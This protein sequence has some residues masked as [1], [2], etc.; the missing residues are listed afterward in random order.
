MTQVGPGT[1]MGDLLRRYWHPVA[2]ESEFESRSTKP[3]RLMGEDLLLFKTLKGEFG[4]VARRC[5]HRGSDLGFGI[6]EEDGLRCSYHGWQYD[7]G[8]ACVHRPFDETVAGAAA[9]RRAVKIAAY[10]VKIKGGMLWAYLGPL[11]APELPDWETF[12]WPNCFAQVVIAEIP[13]NWLQCQENTVDPV[14]FEWMHNNGPKRRAGD[15]GPFSPKTLKMGIE[16]TEYGLLSRRYR[17]GTDESTP[18]WS[19]GRAILWPNGW[20]FGHHFEWKV[21]IDD[22]NTL[23]ITWSVLHVPRECE[24]YAQASIPTWHAPIKDQNG[25]W[26]ISHVGNQD[27]VAWI[28]QGPIADRTHEILGASD[29]GVVTLRRRLLE[30]LDKVAKGQDPRGLIRDPARNVKI[31][32]PCIAREELMNGLPREQMEKHPV[33]GPF[34]RD[35][36]SMAGQPDAVRQAFEEAMGVRQSSFEVHSFVPQ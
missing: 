33:M 30:D 32:L 27:I 28:S 18:L 1:R 5:A 3:I 2:G 14:H 9:L 21:P 35:F 25:E 29:V 8:G 31:P 23:F 6:V 16:D 34:L 17:E 36:Y 4:L 20:Y 7:L 10:P 12:S 11:P 13:C 19:V 15:F 24:P 22:F 26:I